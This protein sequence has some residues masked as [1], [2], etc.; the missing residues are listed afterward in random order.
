MSAFD[1]DL[2][3]NQTRLSDFSQKTKGQADTYLQAPGPPSI[4]TFFQLVFWTET[5]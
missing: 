2:P 5:H 4:H 3:L 1:D